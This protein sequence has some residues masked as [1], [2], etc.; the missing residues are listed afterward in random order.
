MG[1][2]AYLEFWLW[3]RSTSDMR[4]KERVIYWYVNGWYLLLVWHRVYGPPP[5]P[6]STT[7]GLYLRGNFFEVQFDRQFMLALEL[8]QGLKLK[9]IIS[10]RLTPPPP[11]I[12][13]LV[14]KILNIYILSQLLTHCNVCFFLVFQDN[15]F[16]WVSSIKCSI[17]LHIIS[18]CKK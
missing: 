4:G 6:H 1:A 15:T 17:I 5:P 8:G 18:F 3:E 12:Y 16:S 2:G 13:S 7:P 11:Q 9:A 10:Y 14:L